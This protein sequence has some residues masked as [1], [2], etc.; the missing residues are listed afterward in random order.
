MGI[1]WSGDTNLNINSPKKLKVSIDHNE[2][3]APTDESIRLLSEFH[4]KI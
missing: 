3:K 4:E 1:L 2:T